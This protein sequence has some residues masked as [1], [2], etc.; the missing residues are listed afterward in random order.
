MASPEITLLNPNIILIGGKSATGKTFSLKDLKDPE[1]VLYLCTEGNKALPFKSKFDQ[2]TVTDPL[3][4]YQAFE[5]VKHKDHIHTVVIDSLTFL[6]DMYET[7]YVLTSTDGRKAWGEYAQFFKKL[8]QQYI[9][10]TTKNVIL[11]AHTSDVYNDKE[12]VSETFVKIK[13]SVMNTGVESYFNQVVT[14]KKVKL[15]QLA[16]YENDLLE[17]NEEEAIIKMK[18]VFQT[19]LTEE[20]AYERIRSP[21]GMWK[22]EETFVD[23]NIQHVLDRIH[24]YY[25]E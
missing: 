13:G 11:I 8:I 9:A 17:V 14:T 2:R 15:H 19:R 16:D 12:F 6:M 25:S 23:N 21:T 10:E 18:Y 7:Q 20:T 24:S 3:Q 5:W 1:G 22:R 4:V